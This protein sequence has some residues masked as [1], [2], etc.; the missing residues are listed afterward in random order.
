MIT[1]SDDGLNSPTAVT[2]TTQ[3]PPPL[4]HDRWS[5]YINQ[6]HPDSGTGDMEKWSDA[7]L[8]TFCPDGKVTQIECVTTTGILS[9]STGEIMTCTLEGGLACLNDDNAPIKCS[10]YKIRYF[11]K[12]NGKLIVKIYHTVK[13]LNIGT[14]MSEQTV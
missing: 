10:D 12:C 4:C 3:A 6:D 5:N 14:C 7:Q 1:F 13:I 8:A 9:Y 11:C 2:G